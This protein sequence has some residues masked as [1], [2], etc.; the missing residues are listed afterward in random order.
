MPEVKKIMIVRH[1]EKPLKT[2]K[3]VLINGVKS[4][5][6]LV[7]KGWVRA[8]AL[9]QLFRA[10]H[11]DLVTPSHLYACYKSKHAQRALETITPLSEIINVPI[12]TTIQRDNVKGIA[13]EAMALNG[14][15]LIAWEHKCIHLIA[16]EIVS[17]KLV[18]QEWPGDRFDMIYVFTLRDD[19]EYDFKQV[20]QMVVKGDL[21]TPFKL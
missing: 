15:V 9:S 8:G 17:K 7:V 3:G 6:S 13:R 14:N 19:G 21:A 18:P 12:N 11:P 1:G 2:E 20:P 5:D 10:S 4:P 16:N